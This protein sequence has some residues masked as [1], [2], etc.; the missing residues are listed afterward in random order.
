G[1]PCTF[2]ERCDGHGGCAGTRV[3]CESDVCA[4]RTCNGT[5]T[6]TVVL[7]DGAVCSDG[8]ACTIDDTC[9]NG[10][11]QGGAPVVCT[12]MDACHVAGV[13]DPAT[14]QCSHPNAMDG[15]SC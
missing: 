12:A 5:A 4:S 3:T 10:T 11:C 6:C 15:T 2:G 7:H 9:Q 14:G 1:D 13:C 8:N